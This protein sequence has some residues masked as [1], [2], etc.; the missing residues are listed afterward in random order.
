M[1]EASAAPTSRSGGRSFAFEIAL[2]GLAALTLRVVYVLGAKRNDGI[3]ITIGEKAGDQ[4]YYSLAAEALAE[5]RGFVVPWFDTVTL[6][7]ADH[8]PLTALVAAPASLLPGW[9]VLPQRLTMCVVGA[10]AVV[11]IGYL[12]RHVG[13]RRAGLVAGAL[14]AVAPALWINDGLI[15]SESLGALTVAGVLLALYRWRDQ[16]SVQRAAVVGALCGFAVLAR[17]EAALL[18]PITIAPMLLW[19][20]D[21]AGAQRLRQIGAAAA[22]TLLVLAPW[23]VPNLFRFEEPV[24]LSTNDGLT[25]YG[26]NCYPGVYQGDGI[27]LWTLECPLAEDTTGLDQSEVSALYRERAFETIADH[28]DRLPAVVAARVGRVWSF[29]RPEQ[30]ISYNTGEG[31]E[32]WASRAAVWGFYL[33]LVPAAVGGWLLHRRK[34]ALWPLLSQFVNVTLVAALFYG[35]TRFRISAEVALIVLAAV[36]IAALWDRWRPPVTPSIDVPQQV[37]A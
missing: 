9:S 21:V 34:V 7:A 28:T 17:S 6:P 20:G 30:M 36:T 8:P 16:P 37:P 29:Y 13:G 31:R 19:S 11:V 22:L 24:F 10:V 3:D 12:G 26:A 14:A 25:L 33:L 15:M 32:T 35:L 4:Y 27:G 23:V 18:A 2:I 5:G 1:T